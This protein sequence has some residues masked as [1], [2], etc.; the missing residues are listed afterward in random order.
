MYHE[1]PD[2]NL[3]AFRIRIRNEVAQQYSVH[4]SSSNEIIRAEAIDRV[5]GD[6]MRDWCNID[7]G[8]GE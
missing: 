3:Q 2:P 6:T 5:A 4:A 8:R 1:D 7:S